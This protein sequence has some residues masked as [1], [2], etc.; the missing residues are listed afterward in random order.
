MVFLTLAPVLVSLLWQDL[1]ISDSKYLRSTK[2]QLPV[3][4]LQVSNQPASEPSPPSTMNNKVYLSS[5]RH[6]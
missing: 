5:T 6:I 2:L 4:K 3:S 1:S